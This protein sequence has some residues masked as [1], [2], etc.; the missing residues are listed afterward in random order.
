VDLIDQQ[1]VALAGSAASL[2]FLLKFAARK[3][4]AIE[5]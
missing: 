5:V 2:A 1:R 4:P 3:Y